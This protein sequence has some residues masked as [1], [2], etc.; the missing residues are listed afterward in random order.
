MASCPSAG[1][2]ASSMSELGIRTG[3]DAGDI[4]TAAV[5]AFTHLLQITVPSWYVLIPPLLVEVRH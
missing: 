3:S 2:P 5:I 1:V 4:N